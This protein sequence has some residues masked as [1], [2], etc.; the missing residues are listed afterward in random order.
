MA[1]EQLFFV[2]DMVM[3]EE[4]TYSKFLFGDEDNGK[5]VAPSDISLEA[6]KKKLIERGSPNTIV[7]KFEK[8]DSVFFAFLDADDY[9]SEDRLPFISLLS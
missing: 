7:V 8:E 2:V 3:C 5:D 4:K 1:E 6:V 9:C